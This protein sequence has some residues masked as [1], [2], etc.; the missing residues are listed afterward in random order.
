MGKALVALDLQ[1]GFEIVAL[2]HINETC[3]VDDPLGIL[4]YDSNA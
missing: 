1:G 4:I 2:N 3:R